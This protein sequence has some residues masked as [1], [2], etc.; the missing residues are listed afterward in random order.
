VVE[1]VNAMEEDAKDT[2]EEM[3]QMDRQ[4]GSM[5]IHRSYSSR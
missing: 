4:K 5:D 1:R 3:G 2:P